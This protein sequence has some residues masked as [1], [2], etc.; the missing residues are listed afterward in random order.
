MPFHGKTIPGVRKPKK[1]KSKY[2]AISLK[3]TINLTK[4]LKNM[5]TEM[6]L[7]KRSYKWSVYKNSIY[8]YYYG[9]KDEN[10]KTKLMN[11]IDGEVYVES[12]TR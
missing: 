6:V 11:M 3:N 10:E 4:N 5:L 8:I 12:V 2:V 7:C 9:G 1:T